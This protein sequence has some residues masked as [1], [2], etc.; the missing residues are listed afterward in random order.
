MVTMS[1]LGLIER[2]NWE[3]RSQALETR[4]SWDVFEYQIVFDDNEFTFRYF[5]LKREKFS[6]DRGLEDKS[7]LKESS[8]QESFTILFSCFQLIL[9]FIRIE[10]SP[11]FVPVT[12][13]VRH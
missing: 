13:V 7:V 6:R 5:S 8:F 2:L 3:L 9:T 11:V 4:Q 12:L 1:K 10:D